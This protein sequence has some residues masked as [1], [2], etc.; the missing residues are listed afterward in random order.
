MVGWTEE[1]GVI[2][3]S[4]YEVMAKSNLPT[5]GEMARTAPNGRKLLELQ[6]AMACPP[7][8]R[9]ELKEAGKS[10]RG[11]RCSFTACGDGDMCFAVHAAFC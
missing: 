11:L 8:L 1:A 3:T 2:E 10:L 6:Q 9:E 4:F 5:E 7:N